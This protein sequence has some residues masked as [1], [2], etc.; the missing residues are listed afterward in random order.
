V[1]T[2]RAAPGR[3]HVTRLEPHPEHIGWVK[4]E[5]RDWFWSEPGTTEW[6]GPYWTKDEAIVGIL[7]VGGAAF[8]YSREVAW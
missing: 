2:F 6:Q 4:C 3:W 5:G 7:S 8:K 1:E